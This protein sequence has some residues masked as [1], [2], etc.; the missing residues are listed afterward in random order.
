MPHWATGLGHHEV[1]RE[2]VRRAL[3]GERSC[4]G[5][6]HYGADFA[7]SAEPCESC[8]EW[9]NFELNGGV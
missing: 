4:Y 8:V 2:G 9:S 6:R 1:V 7:D 3:K 5:C